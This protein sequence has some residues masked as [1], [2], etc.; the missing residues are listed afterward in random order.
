[1]PTFVHA[2][3]TVQ[4]AQVVVGPAAVLPPAPLEPLPAAPVDAVE[5]RHTN[6]YVEFRA[7]Q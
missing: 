5:V 2:Y 3:C 7:V 4:A 1:M 6:Q